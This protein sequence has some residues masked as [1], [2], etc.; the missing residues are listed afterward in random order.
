M[1]VSDQLYV[2][3]FFKLGCLHPVVY[4]RSGSGVFV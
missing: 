2:Y 3:F 1:E 4:I